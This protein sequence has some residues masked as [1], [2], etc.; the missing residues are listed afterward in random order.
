MPLTENEATRIGN[1]ILGVV[2]NQLSIP[3]IRLAVGRAGFD[4]SRIPGVDSRA[5]VVPAIQRIF[6]EMTLGEKL[7]ALPILAGCVAG[8]EVTDL[9]RRHGYQFVKGEFI[10]VA[11]LDER[12]LQ[13]VPAS[14][15]EL[16]SQAFSRLLDGDENGAVTSC[17]GAVDTATI[18]IFQ[19][20]GL[21]QPPDSFQAKVN[22]VM[23]ALQV[24]EE[25][26]Q[27]MVQLGVN[28]D[29][30][31]E[32]VVELHEA[33]KH[34]ANA[35]QIIRRT[36]GDVHGKKPAYTRLTYDSIKWASAICGLLE[37]KV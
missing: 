4:T 30:A 14:S 24:Y 16:I 32:L 33:T 36:L 22:T 11:V 34:S 12:E 25:M 23:K 28:P 2:A 21:G 6:G 37:G 3:Q 26:E 29:S 10:P 5:A 1:V 19:K 7:I 13:Y 9:L 17:C 20:Y 35:L 15:A 8:P 27:E 18:A 31:K